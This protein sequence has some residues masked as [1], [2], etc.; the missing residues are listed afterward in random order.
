[1][2]TYMRYCITVE[3][4]KFTRLQDAHNHR[5]LLLKDKVNTICILYRKSILQNFSY[6]K[7]IPVYC[8]EFFLL[9]YLN[10]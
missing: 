3:A 9:F 7:D 4:V 2:V 8:S 6:H 1:M 10:I 5:S